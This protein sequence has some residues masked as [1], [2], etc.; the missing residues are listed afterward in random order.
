MIV[1]SRDRI[2][3]LALGL[4][5]LLGVHSASATS[6]RKGAAPSTLDASATAHG[7][8][9]VSLDRSRSLASLPPKC[10]TPGTGPNRRSGAWMTKMV[11]R[12]GLIRSSAVEPH[13]AAHDARAFITNG[14][15][16][17]RTPRP[18]T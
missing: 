14:K 10:A 2:I 7:H 9:S 5:S 16:G 11:H 6:A 18:Y 17:S 8:S 15:G 4:G 13:V 12:R 3:L 1:T